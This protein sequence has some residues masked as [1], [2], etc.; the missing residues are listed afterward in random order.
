VT[1]PGTSGRNRG[2]AT[3]FLVTKKRLELIEMNHRRIAYVA[4]LLTATAFSAAT[5]ADKQVIAGAGPST[6]VIQLFVDK[7]SSDPA[8]TGIEFEV[9]PRS[10]KHAG[11]IKASS[12]YVFGRTGRPLNAKEKGM[13]KG[14]ILL[15]R[16]P[17]AF[18]SG[19]GVNVSSLSLSQLEELFTGKIT[20]WTSVGGSG[21]KVVLVGREPTEALFTVLKKSYP[22]FRK[23]RFAKIFKKDHQVVKFLQSPQGANAIAFG[24][25]PNFKEVNLVEVDGFAAGVAVGLVY[26]LKNS[27][28]D[29]VKSAQMFA[30]TPK[31][32][33]AVQQNGLLAPE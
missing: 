23:A 8:A 11:G 12:K 7:F 1:I 3:S 14:E 17:I 20:D 5:H 4:T 18:A 9:P 25:L 6:K 29:L 19:T 13:N 10:A 16:I 22:F 24:A 27:E 21:G 32:T 15:A 2:R 31:W 26:D 30:S 28:H 33:V